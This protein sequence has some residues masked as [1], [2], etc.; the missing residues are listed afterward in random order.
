MAGEFELN[1][2]GSDLSADRAL[3][4]FIARLGCFVP[5]RSA[6]EIELSGPAPRRRTVESA[7]GRGESDAELPEDI[8]LVLGEE[9]FHHHLV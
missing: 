2:S 7:L 4:A 8:G 1:N 5:A 3:R 6:F 9:V